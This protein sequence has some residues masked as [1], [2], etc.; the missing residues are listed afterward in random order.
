MDIGDFSRR[1]CTQFYGPGTDADI[2]AV[3]ALLEK[4]PWWFPML[5]YFRHPFLPRKDEKPHTEQ[6]LYRVGEDARLAE[7]LIARLRPRVQRRKGDLD[8]LKYCAAMHRHY[9][10]SQKLVRD[11]A[12]HDP[13]DTKTAAAVFPARIRA[14]RDK[15]AELRDTFRELW[16]R[17]NLPANLNYGIDDYNHLVKVWDDAYERA[18]AGRASYDP[19]PPSQ[20]IYHP[21]GFKEHRP[22]RHAFF[23]RLVTLGDEPPA[24]AGIQL[25]G[26]THIRIFVNGRLVGEQFARQNLSAPVNPQLVRIYDI[27]PLLVAGK[28]VIAIEG[29]NYGTEKENLEPGGPSRCAG[30]HLYGEIVERDGRARSILSDPQWKVSENAPD[31]WLAA[32]FDDGQ[33]VAAQADPK[34]TVWVTYPDFEKNVPGFW[35]RR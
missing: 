35:D 2:Q 9:V 4:W 19:R 16:L 32:D 6:E 13:K 11:L 29:R 25:Y 8:Y 3:Y 24:R 26:D 21:S 17:T 31:G 27:K 7:E 34:P 33:W 1:F 15:T 20:W 30:F 18:R 12:Q 14:V 22:V 23:R 10:E 5:D 28:N